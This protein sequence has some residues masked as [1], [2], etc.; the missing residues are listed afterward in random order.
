MTGHNLEILEI[1]KD[2]VNNSDDAN[3]KQLLED[4]KVDD[5]SSWIS[6]LPEMRKSLDILLKDYRPELY[7]ERKKNNQSDKTI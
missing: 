6:K 4:K 1:I 7:E 2:T 5:P 3:I